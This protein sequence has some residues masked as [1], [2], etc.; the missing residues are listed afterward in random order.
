MI[1]VVI[2]VGVKKAVSQDGWSEFHGLAEQ[3]LQT[4]TGPGIAAGLDGVGVREACVK[5]SCPACEFC[6]HGQKMIGD[7]PVL[8][9]VEAQSD[10]GEAREEGD[11][12]LLHEEALGGVA[13]DSPAFALHGAQ[14]LVIGFLVCPLLSFCEPD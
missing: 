7:E 14:S 6:A 13:R 12:A 5:A 1:E 11:D 2:A 3:R 4:A 10:R 9:V 8:F